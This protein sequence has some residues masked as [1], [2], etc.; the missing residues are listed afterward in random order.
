M[1]KRLF[2]AA[3][4]A[5][6]A[7]LAAAPG[8][9]A[10]TIS[11]SHTSPV[12]TSTA[13]SGQP[14][15]VSITGSVTVTGPVAVTLDSNN[16]LTNSGSINIKDVDN[17]TG[18]LIK[19]GFTGGFTNSGSVLI[20]ESY[21]PTDSNNDGV[22]D[23]AF[24]KGTGR[25]GVRLLGPG[26]F[27]GTLN[28][29]AGGSITVQ[30]N[31]SYGLSLEGQ[32]QGDLL[33][34]GGITMTGNDTFA[35][36]QT[37]G[38]TGKVLI[39]GGI[40][41]TGGNATAVD[42]SGDVGGRVAI[43]SA[44][45]ATGFRVTTRSSDPTVNAKLLPEDL[46]TSGPALRIGGNVGGGLFIGAAP[47]GTVA[48]DTTTDADGDGIV[49]SAETTA[50][51][52]SFGP[53]P[54]VVIGAGGRDVHLSAFGTGDNAYGMIIRGS[55]SGSGVFDTFQGNA[56]QIG[57]VGGTVHIDGGARIVGT[58]SSQGYEADSTAIHVLSGASVPQWR[59]EGS[60]IS[61]LTSAKASSATAL[62]MDAGSN[63]T[64]LTNTG[65]IAANVTG[66]L[67]SAFA[68]VD[69]SGTLSTITNDNLITAQLFPAAVGDVPTGSTVAIDASAN[70]TGVSLVQSANPN[71]T[72][73][74]PITPT[75]TGDVLLGSGNNT[76]QVLAG[77]VT[78]ALAM[79][80][81]NS[82]LTVDGG[83]SY[84][85]KLTSSGTLTVAVGSGTLEDD[86][87]TTIKTNSLSIGSSG[88]L[89]VS[90]DPANGNTSTLF[91]AT[92]P[93]TIASGSQIGLHLLSLL[94]SPESY[95]VIT[96]PQLTVGVTD[97]ALAGE[98]PYLYVSSFHAD[99]AAG[100]VAVNIR[101]RTAQEA[102]FNRAETAAYDPV[103]NSLNLDQD[104]QRAFLAQTTQPG[105]TSMMDQMLPD[106]AGGV[107]RALS[108]AA[109]QQ[110]VA[111]GE[112][113]VGEE[114]EGPTRAWT[115]EIV[116]SERKDKLD[117]SGYHSL[118]VG[119]VGGIE[120]VSSRGDALGV[121][122]GFV[123]ANITDPELPSDNLLG[124]S[125]LSAG[126][127]W[128]GDFG[129]VQADAQFGAGFIWVSNKR[130]FLFADSQGVV[131]RAAHSNWNGYSL[132]GRVGVKYLAEMGNFFIQ[133]RVHGDYFRLHES[134]YL[135][136][137][138]GPGFDLA[139]DPRTGDV[140]TVTGS[141]EAG[142][143]FGQT[144]FR[145]RPQVEV[146]YRAVLSGSAG[147]T[148]AQF[149]GATD[150]FS[151]L[152]EQLKNAAIGRV[153]LRVYSNYLD[154]LLDAGAQYN[155]DVTDVDVHLTARTVF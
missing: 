60:I 95:T 128:R 34:A 41:A 118:G 119:A 112:R 130:E 87:P 2:S 86:S 113:P 67:G 72:T 150:S 121:K 49:D 4:V 40:S 23:G 129:P 103:Y 92:G 51:I 98:T 142:L 71:S 61:N 30:G 64:T 27:T 47:A 9:A 85:G 19:P 136:H 26:V 93:V 24:A 126:L 88:L 14:D 79:G 133:P 107:F 100:T 53:T 82:S 48:S 56:L 1:R 91:Q 55:I 63:T 46:L 50:S 120:S 45:Q 31:S 123:T 122:L 8:F 21:S 105:L 57:E 139:V 116:L 83:A 11:D 99:P 78:G 124:V 13:N 70:T 134:G 20:N 96:S 110:G 137:G 22:A 74:A 154:L 44:I 18:V 125:E 62:L 59:V 6:L 80:S 33:Q 3:A 115:Q 16:T 15:D 148:T 42:L 155:K 152:A 76:V 84:V 10:T 135:E 146:G 141:V 111:A 114:Q 127:Y 97:A 149:A 68:V 75:I 5:P 89:V 73:A 140:F 132:E 117:A 90:A 138:G 36:R 38:V 145:W 39:T 65:T 101:R 58:V 25:Y 28:N 66:N 102:G 151:L 106:H 52:S 104:I 17:S 94:T 32:L 131:H 109:E 108:W 143:T 37:G 81:G 77:K 43:Y 12:S 54:A 144:G 35:I 29:A 7:L 153:G 147:V 69:R